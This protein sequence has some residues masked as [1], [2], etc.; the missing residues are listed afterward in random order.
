MH[1]AAHLAFIE[2]HRPA[3]EQH[4]LGLWHLRRW[5][6]LPFLVSALATTGAILGV[7]NCG[8]SVPEEFF[9]ALFADPPEVAPNDSSWCRDISTPL[10]SLRAALRDTLEREIGAFQGVGD[11][12]HGIDVARLLPFVPAPRC[13]PA[14]PPAVPTFPPGRSDADIKAVLGTA[15][16]FDRLETASIAELV[17][18]KA[19][20][21]RVRAHVGS[22]DKDGLATA[23]ATLLRELTNLGV[24]TAESAEQMKT[25]ITALKKA[26]LINPLESA[27]ALV[28]ND[29]SL[30]QRLVSLGRNELDIGRLAGTARILGRIDA[31]LGE[32]ERGLHD[33]ATIDP[34]DEALAAHQTQLAEARA[35]LCGPAA[36]DGAGEVR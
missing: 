22:A 1:L 17:D 26:A 13:E 3:V 16:V 5:D 27:D 8:S 36:T 4:L 35:R 6:A 30:W 24:M 9:D 11:T 20:A 34:L 23:L 2:R 10:R 7:P 12:I 25:A 19:L 31:F 15:G 32:H 14:A 21:E 29:T 28:S 33:A 18:R